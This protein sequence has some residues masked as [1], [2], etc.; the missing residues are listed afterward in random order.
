MQEMNLTLEDRLL[1]AVTEQLK[2]PLLQIA[3]QSELA[4]QTGVNSNE[5]IN[6]I[7]IMALRMIDG[8]QLS[9]ELHNQKLLELE[10]VSLS[11]TLAD[12]AHQLVKLARQYD[13]AIELRLSGKY[14]PIMAHK[15]SLLAA[16]TNLG[17]AFLETSAQ[18]LPHQPMVLGAHKSA[19]G[20]TAGLFSAQTNIATDML[21]RAKA[22]YGTSRQPLQSGLS[23]AGG[24]LFVAESLL[25]VMA[26]NLRSSRHQGMSGLAATFMFSQQL[27]LV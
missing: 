10:P 21:R 3:Q 20:I 7:S 18:H 2:L 14:G 9:T 6:E 12:S 1:R 8:Y 23:S 11:A 4:I 26:T 27:Q 5:S 17:Y 15:P 24:G 13:I 25:N 16:M 19:H 22:L